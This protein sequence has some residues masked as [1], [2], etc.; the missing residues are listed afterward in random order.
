MRARGRVSERVF[1]PASLLATCLDARAHARRSATDAVCVRDRQR[2]GARPRASQGCAARRRR[3]SGHAGKGAKQ[4]TPPARPCAYPTA[5]GWRAAP[6][7]CVTVRRAE[8]QAVQ[9]RARRRPAPP[10]RTPKSPF[11]HCPSANATRRTSQKSARAWLSARTHVGVS[12]AVQAGVRAGR[13]GAAASDENESL[14]RVCPRSPRRAAAVRRRARAPP[15]VQPASRAAGGGGG[16]RERARAGER[17]AG[18]TAIPGYSRAARAAQQGRAHGA[19]RRAA[20]R[21]AGAHPESRS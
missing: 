13:G 9:M 20:C 4:D 10:D 7:T 1:L 6:Y 18:A 11:G 8:R 5:A 16:R 2:G 19:P 14:F 12:P 17:R 21:H 15:R 3:R